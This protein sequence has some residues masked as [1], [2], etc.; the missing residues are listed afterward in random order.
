M[1]ALW[2]GL[3]A[4]VVFPLWLAAGGAD[5]LCHRATAIHRTSGVRES[6]L[7]LVMF[8]QI[9]LPVVAA[10]FLRL[11]ALL[12]AVCGLAVLAHMATTLLDTSYSQPRRHISPIEQQIHSYLEMLP[13]F[14]LGIV[15]V[16]HWDAWR[17]PE[18]RFVARDTALPG[19]GVVLG[20]LLVTLAL[21][22]EELWRCRKSGSGPDSVAAADTRHQN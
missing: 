21:I 16:L 13:L 18:W 5:W 20:A 17:T 1:D 2:I 10:L 8:A 14:A 15:V 6:L 11:N 19:T 3:L 12:L 4:W 7:H 22:L 9:A